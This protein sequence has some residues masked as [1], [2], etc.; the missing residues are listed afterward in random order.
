M[1]HPPP[2]PQDI[3]QA[4]PALMQAAQN[5]DAVAYR[6]LLG[7]ISPVIKRFLRSRLF[8]DTALDDLLQ[9][10]LLAIHAGRHT[11]RPEQPFQHWMFGI[12]RHKLIDYFRKQGRLNAREVSGDDLV[13]F[14][15]DPANTPEEA[16]SYKDIRQALTQ[17]PDKQRRVMVLTKIEGYSMAEAAAKLGMTETA[18]KVT[19]HRA[20][21]RLKE[22]LIAYGYT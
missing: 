10:I 5:G 15:A 21:K 9:E 3:A 8:S 17:L 4:W 12:A 14:M 6:Q 13:T 7:E 22:W 11:Y 19:A 1:Q 20:Y 18:V 16:L 2:N